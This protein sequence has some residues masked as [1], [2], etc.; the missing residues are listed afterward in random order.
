M[1]DLVRERV[2]HL[3]H[4][5]QR[6][7]PALRDEILAMG[8]AAVAP[9]VE[10][11]EDERLHISDGPGKGFAPIHAIEL[12]GELRAEAAIPAMLRVLQSTNW[13]DWIHD[14]VIRALAKVGA[15]A[16]EPC[17][18]AH[19]ET[20][21]EVS[22]DGLTAVLAGLGVRDDRVFEILLRQLEEEPDKA[23]ASLAEYGDPA[24]L[25]YLSR[26]FDRY[27]IVERDSPFANHSA[28]EIEAAIEELGGE[29]TA[30]QKAKFKRAVAPADGFRRRLNAALEGATAA[31]SRL[32]RRPGRNDPCHCGS[33]KKYK[34]C[35]LPH[36]EGQSTA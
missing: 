28:V 22:R 17:L 7:S 34:K 23:A 10:I 2:R 24:A 35:H 15:P 32:L 31:P 21:S 33:G 29:L 36:D 27:E 26:A 8:E 9:L 25:P 4:V 13:M 12:L 16:L 6:L 18:R 20:S 19:A 5:G 1:G 3:I 11:I 14:G 30:A